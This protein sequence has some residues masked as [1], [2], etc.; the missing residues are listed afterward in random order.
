MTEKHTWRASCGDKLLN[1]SDSSLFHDVWWFHVC[2]HMWGSRRNRNKIPYEHRRTRISSTASLWLWQ[3]ATAVNE[4]A[5]WVQASRHQAA[6]TK[7]LTKIHVLL[8][9]DSFPRVSV[10]AANVAPQ[11]KKWVWRSRNCSYINR[12]THEN[13]EISQK[14]DFLKLSSWKS[15][16]QRSVRETVVSHFN[17]GKL[18]RS[19]RQHS[20]GEFLKRFILGL[21]KPPWD[22]PA[23][24][25]D[26]KLQG[27]HRQRW[28]V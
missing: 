13:K 7:Y 25:P 26:L 10:W 1:R 15:V 14:C 5:S 16:S 21:V 8:W 11:W 28:H 24:Q 4:R 23:L 17:W 12:K 2:A 22:G 9:P 20:S 3:R 18:P 6:R 19:A 27:F